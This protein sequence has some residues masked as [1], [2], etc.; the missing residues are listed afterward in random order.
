MCPRQVIQ[1]LNAGE[2]V[3][4]GGIFFAKQ[5]GQ[6]QKGDLYIAGRNTGPHLLTCKENQHDA[7]TGFVQPQL[8]FL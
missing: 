1:K 8:V 4:L 6:I 2:I 3:E 7:G 5:E